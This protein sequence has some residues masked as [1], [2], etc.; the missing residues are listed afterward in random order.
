MATYL[1][2]FKRTKNNLENRTQN[3]NFT[4]EFGRTGSDGRRPAEQEANLPY[5][6]GDIVVIGTIPGGSVI[7]KITTLVG[8]AFD[9]GTTL[10]LSVSADTPALSLLPLLQ[11]GAEIPIDESTVAINVP[12]TTS[13]NRGANGILLPDDTGLASVWLGTEDMDGDFYIVASFVGT[14][15]LTKGSLDVVVEY[16][17]F[18]TNGGAY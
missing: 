9:T 3:K 2:E 8:E 7:T 18:V 6:A 13:G 1:D 15:V 11:G 5:S 12:L 16:N 4:L 10:G 17:R 14:G